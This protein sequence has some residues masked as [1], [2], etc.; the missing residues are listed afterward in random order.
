MLTLKGT[1]KQIDYA[2]KIRAEFLAKA[3]KDY[4][5]IKYSCNAALANIKGIVIT[6]SPSIA[7]LSGKGEEGVKAYFAQA[8]QDAKKAVELTNT[9]E[10]AS[11]WIE[12][13][14]TTI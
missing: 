6:D 14:G 5:D 13:R 1:E 4:N 9:E 7:K 8:Q 11:Y 10:N 2:N 3:Q 12:N